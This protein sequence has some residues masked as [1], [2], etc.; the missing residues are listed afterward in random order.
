MNTQSLIK[1]SA[2]I[3]K[4]G[5]SKELVSIDKATN[6]EVGKEIIALVISNLYKAENEV[7]EFIANFKGITVEEAKLLNIIDLLK[8]LTSTEGIKDF[9]S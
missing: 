8:E 4:M 9:L 5:I 7:Y 2:I 3:D 1:L 6:E